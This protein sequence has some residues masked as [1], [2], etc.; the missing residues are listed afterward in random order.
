MAMASRPVPAVRTLMPRRS[1]TLLRAKIFRTSS[2]TTSTFLSHQGIIGTMQTVQHILLS[3]R[4]IGHNAVQKQRGL[5]Q[6]AF[7]DSTPFTTTLRASNA[8]ERLLPET[9]LFR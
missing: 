8:A 6:Q 5:I 3:G 4:Q 2:S 9:I 7:R 1:R